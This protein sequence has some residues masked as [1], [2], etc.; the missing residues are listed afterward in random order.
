VEGKPIFSIADGYVS[1]VTVGLYGFGNAV[2]VQHP[3]GYTSIY[4]HLKKFTPR[5]AA[6]LR[7]WQ[8]EHHSYQADVRLKATDCPVAQGQLIA[9]SGNTGSSQAPHLHLEIHDTRTWNM[10]DP[11]QFLGHCVNDHTPP[12][13]H[14]FMACPQ[15]GEGVFNGGAMKQNFGFGSHHLARKFTAWGKVG[16][17][18]W[19]NDYMEGTYNNYGIRHTVLTVD[20]QEIFRSDVNNIPVDA[21]RLVNSWGDYHHYLSGRQEDD[22]I[23]E[24]LP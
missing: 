21:N 17:A 6:A 7:C 18:L 19:A 4:C 14:G 13:A 23:Q 11:L 16:F 20:G 3:E 9:V 12:Q 10:L 1:R 22:R 2:Y 15:E 8:Y 5:I 24:C